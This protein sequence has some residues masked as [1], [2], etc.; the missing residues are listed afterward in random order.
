VVNIQDGRLIPRGRLRDH[1][2][3][4]NDAGGRRGIEWIDKSLT[5]IKSDPRDTVITT[6]ASTVTRSIDQSVNKSK[7]INQMK[8]KKKKK[9]T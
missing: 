1:I 6:I 2:D 9:K 3:D 5:R 4:D 7:S 8:M